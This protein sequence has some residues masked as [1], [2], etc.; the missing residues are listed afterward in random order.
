MYRHNPQTKRAKQLVDEGA[1]GELRLVRSAFSYSLYDEDNIRLRTEVEGGA[2][3]DV[4]CY[5]VSGSR[6][7]G[8]EPEHVFGEA[9]FGPSGT[10]W[11]FAGTMRF[12]D[13]VI[14]RLRLRHRDARTAT[15][16]RRSAAKARSSSTTH[17]TA[18]CR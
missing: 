8:G 2:L 18:T 5:N 1:I 9:W 4:G 13:N 14:A 3:M 6:L 15:S 17:G 7:F 10:D 11:V 12:P 16:S